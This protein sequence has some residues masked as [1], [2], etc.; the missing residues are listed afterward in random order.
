[1]RFSISHLGLGGK[2]QEYHLL[3]LINHL[4]FFYIADARE[5]D[6]EGVKGWELFPIPEAAHQ[7]HVLPI[8][9][10]VGQAGLSLRVPGLK[11]STSLK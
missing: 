10:S 1:M 7:I 3:D 2:E 4:L 11:E 9:G 5:W 6:L 8:Q